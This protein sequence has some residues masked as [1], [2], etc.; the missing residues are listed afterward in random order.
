MEK[1]TI[2]K[3]PFKLK[4]E[5]IKKDQK[6]DFVGVKLDYSDFNLNKVEGFKVI[7][8]F[9]DINTTICDFQTKEMY[10]RVNDN[11]DVTFI[12]ISTDSPEKQGNWCAANS[13]QDMV[14]VS[15]EKYKDFGNKTNLLITKIN[16]LHRAFIILD[17]D[18]TVLDVI[19]C[20][21]VSTDPDYEALDEWLLKI[22]LR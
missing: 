21:E 4:G 8:S 7:S 18:N 3:I 6:L 9:T 10:L 14:F 2:K 15:D 5:I 22:K 16:K 11:P 1:I 17:K 12:S 20:K 13:I 19:A